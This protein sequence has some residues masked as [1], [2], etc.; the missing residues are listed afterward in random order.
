MNVIYT[1][2]AVMFRTLALPDDPYGEVEVCLLYTSGQPVSKINQLVK[3]YNDAK[4]M[5]KSFTGKG[6][7]S[8][9]N[10]MF[11]GF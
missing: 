11:R 7:N 10:K 5:M 8:R 2:F 9:L 4:K 6:G 1:R 3:R